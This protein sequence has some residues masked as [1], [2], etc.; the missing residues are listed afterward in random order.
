MFPNRRFVLIALIVAV[1]FLQ[2]AL[3]G[4]G[5]GRHKRLY[6]VPRP[7]EVSIDGK[8][9]DWDLS[10]QI[11]MFVVSETKD[12]QRVEYAMM[13]DAEA[14]YVG[15][16][17][18]DPNPMRNRHDPQRED[19]S[20]G[21]WAA[22]AC[23]LRLGI[24]PEVPFPLNT[25]VWDDK[26]PDLQRDIIH[27]T[28]WYY[29][30][31]KQPCL[32]MKYGFEKGPQGGMY[33][34]PD[35]YHNG[36][37][38]PGKFQA[39]YRMGEDGLSYTMEY[40]IP[41]ETLGADNPPQGGDLVPGTVQFNWSRPDGRKTAGGASWA[42]DVMNHSGV[43]FQ[44]ASTWG[45]MIF[46]KEGDIPRD[47]VEKGVP[48]EKPLPLTVEYDLEEPGYVTIAL[49]DQEGT[50]V[51]QIITE[52]KRNGGH[53]VE[54]WD[55]LN[56]F[57]R[58][59]PAGEY[60]WKGLYHSGLDLEYC[61]SVHNSGRP[62]YKTDKGSSEWGANWGN[63]VE[64][65]AIEGG[66]LLGWPVTEGCDAII[67]V[68]NEG[69]KQWGILDAANHLAAG[70]GRF[71]A[72]KAGNVRVY[73]A[74]NGAR[75]SYADGSSII[76]YSDDT[77][78]PVK[79]TGLAWADGNLYVSYGSKNRII[80]HDLDTAQPART[81]E[82]KKPGRLAVDSNGDVFAISDKSIVR[83]RGDEVTKL[84]DSHLDDPKGVAL[85]E[86]GRMY[87]SNWGDLQNVS[88]FSSAGQ[89]L[90]SIG[91]KGGRPR[92]G[93]WIAEGM[94]RPNGLDVDEE[95]QLWVAEDISTP[96]RAGVWNA[97]DGTFIDE[98]F[99]AG[100]YNTYASM[101]ANDPS[102]VYCHG[103]QWK[104]DLEE[105][106][107]RPEAVVAPK[108]WGRWGHMRVFTAN[109]GRQYA[110]SRVSGGTVLKVRDG[111][112][113][114]NVA[115]IVPRLYFRDQE[116][117]AE[118][119]RKAIERENLD[120]KRRFLRRWEKRNSM[121]WCDTNGDFT[122]Q[123]SEITEMADG[124]GWGGFRSKWV[125]GDLTYYCVLHDGTVK[126][127]PARRVLQNGAPV[128]RGKDIEIIEPHRVNDEEIPRMESA[129]VVADT[130]SE[131]IFAIGGP[132]GPRRNAKYPIVHPAYPQLNCYNFEGEHQWGYWK[133]Q[134]DWHAAM[135]LDVSARGTCLGVTEL[136]GE[137]GGYVMASTYN[138]SKGHIWS[139]DGLYVGAVFQSPKTGATGSDVI[140]CEW[141][142]G[143]DFVKTT[144]DG[145]YFVLIGDQDGRVN[146]V[147]GLDTVKRLKGGTYTI[148]K[149]DHRKVVEAQQQYQAEKA[150]A[151]KLVIVRGR[152]A[153][154]SSEGVSKNIDDARGFT[155]KIAYDQKNLYV[156]YDVD[157]PF[158]L[159]NSIKQINT[160]YGGGNCLDIQLATNPEADPDRTEPAP[161]DVR[162][163]VTRQ[164]DK[165]L[166]ILYRP[167]VKGFDGEPIVL[168]SPVDRE[169]FDRIGVVSDEIQL[170]YKP[171]SGGFR[172]TVTVP[173]ELLGWNPQPG[174]RTLMDL[175]YIFGTKSG[176]AAALRSYWANNSFEA[177]VV[178]DI[179]DESRLN[180]EHW[181]EA[182]VE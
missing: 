123:L 114:R 169:S 83:M 53:N 177:K 12:T 127:L 74:K 45:K 22:D 19:Y 4:S 98:F 52:G 23:Q 121:L 62:P 171:R 115:A 122:P 59:M 32:R 65:C 113:F 80:R 37:V 131:L 3:A 35:E 120:R 64:A 108:D 27:L 176:N 142:N 110:F 134:T 54:R 42:Y 175:G 85:D 99:G 106:T 26:F 143:G 75:L 36:I 118:Y 147:L 6:V 11:T 33:H 88:I 18:R 84:I 90:R 50:M 38:P 13:Y 31:G 129:G 61:V 137:A 159:T 136:M 126:R 86:A 95:G 162:L 30:D 44:R 112:R 8:L 146:E 111:D 117:F 40:R 155:A 161:G 92:A 105:G 102:R 96:K 60:T 70:N 73:D 166:A 179:P 14:V 71:Y 41:W 144:E 78:D 170:D 150:K 66:V 154:K 47:L 15:A 119:R 17:L 160:V 153:L 101:D 49:Y 48:P 103:V 167:N 24:S 56:A 151:Q 58:P 81:W 100:T 67:F 125:D 157:S 116:W 1:G 39:A 63:V 97:A 152:E 2:A 139:A 9:D 94:R 178:G 57:G 181:G 138:D 133:L 79:V 51:R 165:P 172:A 55:G 149:E 128:Y 158:P 163:I 174:Q 156:Y 148:S 109:N 21:Y 34:I 43:T 107:K 28:L 93:R 164:D 46:S 68:N 69:R 29:T 5:R 141:H 104:V 180:P 168:E 10:G 20:R 25:T 87:V 173:L 130:D 7:G 124:A 89:Y 182:V 72:T 140:G 91:R 132:E 145:R 77:S 76:N 82:V 16:K 135:N